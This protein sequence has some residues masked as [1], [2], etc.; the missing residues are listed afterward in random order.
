MLPIVSPMGH[1]WVPQ[2]YDDRLQRIIL[3]ARKTIEASPAKGVPAGLTASMDWIG[4]APAY[5]RTASTLGTH[6]QFTVRPAST[7]RILSAS[8]YTVSRLTP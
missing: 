6:G 2:V 7:G 3:P 1:P 4:S 8:A 5:V